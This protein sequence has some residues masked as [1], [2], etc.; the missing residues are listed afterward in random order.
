MLRTREV[1]YDCL[2]ELF[3]VYSADV[4]DEGGKL[5]DSGSDVRIVTIVMLGL[6]Q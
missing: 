1:S 3:D 2:E 6:S 5:S 4:K